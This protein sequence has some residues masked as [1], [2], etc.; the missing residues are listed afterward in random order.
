MSNDDP[1]RLAKILVLFFQQF[2]GT[3]FN[4]SFMEELGFENIIEVCFTMEHEDLEL[5]PKLEK[6]LRQAVNQSDLAQVDTHIVEVCRLI[7]LYRALFS[8]SSS[9]PVNDENTNMIK[10]SLES[11]TSEFKEQVALT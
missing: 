5:P 1:D 4:Q 11:F 6:A 7:D 2:K 8:G 3:K 9:G 10:E